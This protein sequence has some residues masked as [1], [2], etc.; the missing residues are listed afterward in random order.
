[1]PL[2]QILLIAVGLAMD[3]FAVSLASGFSLKSS[4][5]FW[6][7][8]I[9]LFFGGFQALMP[10]L[11]WFGGSLFQS[12][13]ESF[14]HW[15]AFGLLLI[16]GCRMIYEAFSSHSEKKI[17][18][19]TNLVVLFGLAIATSIDALAVGLSFSLLDTQ[20]FLPALLIGVV[21]FIISFYG[22]MLGKSL[23]VKWGERAHVFGG[24]VLI[25]IG[26]KILFEHLA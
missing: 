10:V 2:F 6:S 15:I 1:M 18:R 11:G 26:I 4:Y 14:D 21:T 13:I 9:A 23:G 7:C 12:H 3:A 20:I 22:V 17:I 19:P 8:I 16:I 25:L 24:I 5:L